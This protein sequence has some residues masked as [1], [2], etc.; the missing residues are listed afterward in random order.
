MSWEAL[1]RE[2][3]RDLDPARESELQVG[4]QLGEGLRHA[5]RA[6]SMEQQV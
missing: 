4:E 3:Y 5:H 6:W 2:R 1:Q